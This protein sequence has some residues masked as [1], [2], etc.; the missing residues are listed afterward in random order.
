MERNL[1]DTIKYDFRIA[2]ERVAKSKHHFGLGLGLRNGKGLWNGSLLRT[3]FRL[4]GIRHPDDM[5]AII[6]KTLHRKLNDKPI[7]FKEQKDYYKEYWKVLRNGRDALRIWWTE[8]HPKKL[9]DSIDKI[10]NSKFEKGR[11]VLGSVGAMTPFENGSASGTDVK[12]IAK[13]VE[14]NGDKLKLKI[15]ELDEVEQRFKMFNKIGDTID[16]HTTNV[17]LIPQTED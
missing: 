5:S 11:L 3:Y 17:F 14:Q 6:L 16:S 15:L 8:K 2:P 10:Y 13:I 9:S 1:N 7:K 12:M 4:N